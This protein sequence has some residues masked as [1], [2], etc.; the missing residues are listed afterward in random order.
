MASFKIPKLDSPQVRSV[1]VPVIEPPKQTRYQS[2][3]KNQE[4]KRKITVIQTPPKPNLKC[5]DCRTPTASSSKISKVWCYQC[6][7]ENRE[8]RQLQAHTSSAETSTLSVP[9]IQPN[10]DQASI[11][12]Q[13]ETP[14]KKRAPRCRNKYCRKRGHETCDKKPSERQQQTVWE[15]LGEQIQ[16]TIW[17]RLDRRPI[18]DDTSALIPTPTLTVEEINQIL[19]Q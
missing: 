11:G 16:P 9:M 7:K 13:T 8:H 15:R 10:P 12:V 2:R 3:P 19:P 14:P 6:Y 17:E 1:I 18:E 5:S 4:H